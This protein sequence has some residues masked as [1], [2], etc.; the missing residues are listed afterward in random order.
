MPT[1][2]S[3]AI[4][5]VKGLALAHPDEVFL[6]RDG[7]PGD[8]RFFLV[9]GDGNR[10]RAA[11][12][13]P[14]VAVR[15]TYDAAREQLSLVFPDG[16][17]V[18]GPVALGEALA[19]P[20]SRGRMRGRLVEG[21][22]SEALG[23][24]LGRPVQLVRADHAATT[25]RRRAVSLVSKASVDELRR[26]SGEASLDARRFR[27]SVEV[28]GCGP[29]EEDG[30]VGRVVALGD[31]VARVTSPLERC[32]MTKYNPATGERDFDTLGAIAAYR[33]L[34]DGKA[35]D[36]GVYGEVVTPGRVRVGD[37]VVVTS[38]RAP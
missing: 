23:R 20:F 25:D 22:W 13:A 16:R 14:L 8:R 29:H 12:R 6:G 9:G 28:D 34:R 36:F 19:T 5:P 17:E 26:R 15:A 27:M 31:A 2:A 21:P 33:G 35:I 18:G 7:V 32:V 37:A 11:E 3:L 10:L 24:Y 1:V 38:S 30:W 4:A